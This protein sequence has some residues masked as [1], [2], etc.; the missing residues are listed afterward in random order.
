MVNHSLDPSDVRLARALLHDLANPLLAL[1]MNMESILDD[2]DLSVALRDAVSESL[3]SARDISLAFETLRDLCVIQAG[4]I[5]IVAGACAL[6]GLLREVV[7]SLKAG[8][9]EKITIEVDGPDAVV[10][11]IDRKTA[12]LVIHGLVAEAVDHASQRIVIRI[13]QA[14]DVVADVISVGASDAPADTVVIESDGIAPIAGVDLFAPEACLHPSSRW[15]KLLRL[16]HAAAIVRLHGGELGAEPSSLGGVKFTL[17]F[18][19]VAS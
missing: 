9:S 10:F 8:V 13:A 4:E 3:A 14:A 1:R 18:F 6:P 5:P 19:K 15:N 11:P 16:T 7:D 2:A 17:S 12:F